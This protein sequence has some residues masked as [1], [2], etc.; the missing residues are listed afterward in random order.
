RALRLERLRGLVARERL[1]R[2]R[3]HVR[4]SRE[5]TLDRLHLVARLEVEAESTELLDQLPVLL[6][7]E[8]FGDR[9]GAVR[10]D[11]LDLL[12]VLLGRAH[13]LVDRAEVRREVARRY[14]AG[15]RDVQP[16]EDPVE[17]EP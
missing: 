13:E 5:R 11:A 16:G 3:D 10:P 4:L 9:L 15:L 1:E 17:L 12:D 7:R 6:V 2:A 8:P 14:P